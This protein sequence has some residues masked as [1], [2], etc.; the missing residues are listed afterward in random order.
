[1]TTDLNSIEFQQRAVH[2]DGQR[3]AVLIWLLATQ[4]SSKQPNQSSG[5]SDLVLCE[6]AFT[7]NLLFRT[8]LD[9]GFDNMFFIGSEAF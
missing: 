2:L 9:F 1:M 5:C 8:F 4:M 3:A 7:V 6:T